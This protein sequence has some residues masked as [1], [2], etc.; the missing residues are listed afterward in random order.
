MS[1]IFGVPETPDER[2]EREQM[3]QRW[4]EIKQHDDRISELEAALQQLWNVAQTVS[5]DGR[6]G[7]FVS[8]DDWRRLVVDHVHKK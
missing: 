5:V 8:D 7:C 3:E 1:K 6:T 4:I 2:D